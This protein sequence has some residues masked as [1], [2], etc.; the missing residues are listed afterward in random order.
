MAQGH[1]IRSETHRTSPRRSC[2]S[3]ASIRAE[4]N[5]NEQCCPGLEQAWCIGRG[6]SCT[7]ENLG[8]VRLLHFIYTF[9]TDTGCAGLL[10]IFQWLISLERNPPP[11][12][13]LLTIERLQGW[14]MLAYYPLEHLYYLASHGIVPSSLPTLSSLFSSSAKPIPIDLNAVGIWSCRFW[15]AYVLLQFAHLREDR[16]LLLLRERS[17]KK[18][19]QPATAGELEQMKA[20][21]DGYWNEIIVN[22]GYLPLTVHW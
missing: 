4:G 1:S 19:K 12:R 20:S 7:L 10:P 9:T 21:W 15:A 11:T 2:T 8:Y 5:C 6:Y 17:I 14:S 13:K 3:S 18:G 22:V 16:K